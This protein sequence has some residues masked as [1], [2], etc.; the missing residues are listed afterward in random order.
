MSTSGAEPA[1]RWDVAA[2][3]R[4]ALDGLEHLVGGLGTAILS[5]VALFLVLV[6]AVAC[7]VGVGVV[8][9]PTTLRVLRVVADRERAR[10]SRWGPEI[11]GP[12]PVPPRLREALRDASV[13]RELGWV[14]VHSTLGL[15]LGLAALTLPL[16]AVRDLSYPLWWKLEG[17][18][19]TTAGL[20]LWVVHDWTGAFATSLLGLLWLVVSL[21]VTPG[22]ARLQAWPGRRLLPPDRGADLALRVAELTA[23]RAAAL[24]AHTAELRRIERALHDGTQNRLVAVTVLLGAARRALTRDTATAEAALDRAQGAAEQALAELRAVVRGILPPVLADRS[25]SDALSALAADCPVPC[26]VDADLPE[27][28]AASVEATAY[29]AV[30]EALT[31]VARHSGARQATVTLRR[32]DDRL[33]IEITDDGRGGADE[34]TGSG[35]AGIRRRVEAHDG[36]FVLTSPPGGPTALVVSL[37]CGS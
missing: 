3:A 29:F 32:H 26:R 14:A 33:R 35:L 27:R 7:L 20:G 16:N 18:V 17:D 8:L 30:A 31:N 36:T 9:A 25:L 6:T 13:R 34:G 1:R 2:R 19:D 21:A 15:F 4:T 28:C 23:T 11:L 24:D 37:P 10:L 22:M 12:D 5:V